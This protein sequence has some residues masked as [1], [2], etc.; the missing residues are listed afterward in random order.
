MAAFELELK[1]FDR[2]FDN[3]IPNALRV[4]AFDVEAGEGVRASA[5]GLAI[6]EWPAC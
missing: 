4:R 2:V 6:W 3:G 5:K 1:I